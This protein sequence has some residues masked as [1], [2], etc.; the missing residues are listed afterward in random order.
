MAT[1]VAAAPLHVQRVRS[2]VF[3][4]LTPVE[5]GQLARFGTK[6]LGRRDP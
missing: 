3:D 5:V 2:R 4:A 1:I 6:V